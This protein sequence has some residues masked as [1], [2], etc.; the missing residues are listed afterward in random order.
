ME[1]IN[2]WFFSPHERH[3]SH[4]SRTYNFSR[5]LVKRGHQVT[6]FSNSYCHRT[7]VEYLNPHEKWRIEEIDGV[8]IAL[9]RTFHYVGNGWRRGVNMFSFA[10]R[11]MQVAK[12]LSVKPDVIVGDSVPPLAGWV[13][14]K[15]ARDKGA[16]F[17]YQVRDVW[18][19]A[20]VYDGVLSKRSLVY[21]SFRFIEKHLYRKSHR[22]CSTLPFLHQHVL[23][24]GGDPEGI[25]W[26]PNGV[27]LSCYSNLGNYDGGDKLPLVAMYVGAFGFEHDVITIVKAAK[28]LQQ[29]G[30]DKYHFVIVGDGVKRSECERE[31]SLLEL[32]NIEFLDSVDK[33]KVPQLQENS[34]ILI[35]CLIDSNAYCF[36]INLNKLYDYFASGRPV[37]FS[38]RS[39]NDPVADSKAGFSIPPEDPQ[40]MAEVLDKYSNMSPAKRIELGKLARCYAE[41]EFDAYKL[42]GRMESLLFQAVS[43]KNSQ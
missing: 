32:S 39:P 15:L 16:A 29:K 22:I 4:G 27:D 41:K 17:I 20:L 12:T 9:L 19:I 40:A 33:S 21:Y 2:V 43:D 42:A 23:E 28:I 14:S 36:G 7:H 5:E 38:G 3:N 37:I 6:M 1:K 34:D 26:I 18:P 24:S 11:A 30:N 35:A 25:T 10:W 13:A 8:R 31:V